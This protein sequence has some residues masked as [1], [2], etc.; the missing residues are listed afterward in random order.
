MRNYI[1]L[2]ENK[3]EPVVETPEEIV[4]AI[5]E[6][7]PDPLSEA[8]RSFIGSDEFLAEAVLDESGLLKAAG[9]ALA[10]TGLMG[11][12]ASW[13]TRVSAS[14]HPESFSSGEVDL[15][16]D[17]INQGETGP[18]AISDEPERPSAFMEPETAQTTASPP[19]A[20]L[21]AKAREG[22]AIDQLPMEFRESWAYLALTI[23]GEARGE[24][25]A[26]MLAVGNVMKNRLAQ[27]RWGDSMQKVVTAH[28]QGERGIVY[29]FSC[30]GDT[31]KGSMM[32][33]YRMDRRLAGLLNSNPREYARL[34]AKLEKKEDWRAWIQSKD[35]AYKILKGQAR[36]NSGGANHYHTNAVSPR[37]NEN[38]STTT[39]VGN[40]VF[41]TDRTRRS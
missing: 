40:H 14:A 29:Q 17:P 22:A 10:I 27:G 38:M 11:G 26:G 20:Q 25:R 3:A 15:Y 28:K 24:E 23:W 6:E 35:I 21:V 39:K 12:A 41:F 16:G 32:A 34:K 33:M 4:E 7:T 8:Y 9:A 36:D 5:V 31:N 19:P 18:L 2:L 13:A 37:W 30:W 1:N